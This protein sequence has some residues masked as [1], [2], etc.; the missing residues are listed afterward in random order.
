MGKLDRVSLTSYTGKIDTYNCLIVGIL[1][2]NNSGACYPVLLRFYIIHPPL[3]LFLLV[4][5][6]SNFS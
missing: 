2:N 4:M 5:G 6:F 1:P 3:E